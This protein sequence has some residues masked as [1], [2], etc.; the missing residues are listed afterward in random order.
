MKYAMNLHS[1]MKGDDL[2][3]N[4]MNGQFPCNT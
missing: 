1:Q 3:K 4:Q 2:F